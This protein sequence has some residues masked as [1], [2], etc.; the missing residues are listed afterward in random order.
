M[1]F[2]ANIIQFCYYGF[3]VYF[4][5]NYSDTCLVLLLLLRMF[6]HLILV[7]FLL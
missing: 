2:Y 1:Y 6:C 3:T 7:S 4:E 5:I